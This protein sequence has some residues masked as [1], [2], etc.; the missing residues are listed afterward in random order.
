MHS[1]TA[2]N[3]K[4]TVSDASTKAKDAF[5][6]GSAKQAF[7]EVS[8]KA[9]NA[10]EDAKREVDRATSH[11]SSQAS[12][13]MDAIKSGVATAAAAVP[14]M[15]NKG[16]QVAKDAINSDTAQNIKE[17]VKETVKSAW[18]TVSGTVTGNAEVA[19]QK[20]K[21]HD[22]NMKPHLPNSVQP[23]TVES[24]EQKTKSE[25]KDSVRHTKL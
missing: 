9:Y 5:T 6:G 3:V 22:P 4:D 2:K 24:A 15:A 19:K 21:A 10:K 11:A 1:T 18:D 8:N 20:A 14:P 7:N 17:G 16:Y 12:G 23:D 13:V 25:G